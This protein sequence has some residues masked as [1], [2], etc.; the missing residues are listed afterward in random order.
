LSMRGGMGIAAATTALDCPL[1]L[2]FEIH[3]AWFN[4]IRRRLT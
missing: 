4:A 2:L 3:I 1:E